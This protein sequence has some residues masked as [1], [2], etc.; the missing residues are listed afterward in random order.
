M[1]NFIEKKGYK[2]MK[3]LVILLIA[4]CLVYSCKQ[5]SQENGENMSD[6][7]LEL[8]QVIHRE[9]EN[10]VDIVINGQLVTSLISTDEKPVLYPVKT[11][12]G[13]TLTRGFPLESKAGE[14]VDHPHHVG[15][16]LNYGDVNGLDFWNNSSAIPEDKKDHYGTIE[17][18]EIISTS[19]G[20]DK[21]VLETNSD[22]ITPNGKTLLEEFTRYEFR[23]DTANQTY[24]IDRYTQL[25]A[26]DTLV[27]FDDNK[28]G[29]IAVRVTRA[30]ELPSDKPLVFTDESGKATDVPEMNNEGVNGD[31]LSSEGVT[32]SD[33]WGTRAKWVKLHSTID[34]EP[35][36]ITI[37]DHPDNIGY[38]T[39]WHARG[40]GLFA[41]N[42]LGQKVFSDGENELNFKLN[43]EESV[44]FQH[45][46]IV[47][48]GSELNVNEIN[49]QFDKF[50]EQAITN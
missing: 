49:E 2:Y 15:I 9:N 5:G 28:E 35:V 7:E 3:Q 21:G 43:P 39:Y 47:H 25:K 11:L 18:K 26:Q 38:P 33:V 24:T 31:Y 1:K 8:V 14:R 17:L 13:T 42:P 16:W 27:T 20:N 41:A 30:M 19:S 46:I 10:K 37:L 22:W 32:G 50:Q 6:Q 44:E 12:S 23:V 45:R 36:S 48:S 40:Y 34:S 29:M 4:G